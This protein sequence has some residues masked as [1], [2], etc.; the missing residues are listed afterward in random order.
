MIRNRVDKLLES[1]LILLML[2]ILGNVLWQVISRY[3]FQAPSSLTDELSRFALI[4]IGLLGAA[5]T[6]GKGLHLAIDIVPNM[7]SSEKR[8][9]LDVLINILLVIFSFSILV[10]GGSRLAWLTFVLDQKS[11]AMEVPLGYIYAVLPLSGLLIIFY[12]LDNIRE[13]LV[14]KKVKPHELH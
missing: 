2:L 5:F 9:K 1:L 7:L 3:L 10:L 8:Y 12:C 4:W 11:A 13:K 6:T 14:T